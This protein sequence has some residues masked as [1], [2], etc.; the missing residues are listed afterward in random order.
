[1]TNFTAG[2]QQT[3][4]IWIFQ[5]LFR[6]RNQPVVNVVALIVIALTFLPILLVQVLTR[7]P[8]VARTSLVAGRRT[9]P[10]AGPEGET[11]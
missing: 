3:L 10:A 2:Q 8:A 4:P 5:A 1:M 6:P 9:R 7:D 11:A